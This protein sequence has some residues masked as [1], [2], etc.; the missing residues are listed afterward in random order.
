MRQPLHTGCTCCPPQPMPIDDDTILRIASGSDD[1]MKASDICAKAAELVGGE[2]ERTHGPK[3]RNHGNTAT[4]IEALWQIRSD[5]N[6]PVS[7]QDVCVINILQKISRIY[8][9]AYN[10]DDW[11]DIAGWAGCGGEIAARTN[12]AGLP[13]NG[14]A[15]DPRS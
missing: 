3:L 2:R 9:G 15:T 13:P 12:N 14:D 5:P 10:P 4:L 11:V 8:S 6:A 1:P 7:P